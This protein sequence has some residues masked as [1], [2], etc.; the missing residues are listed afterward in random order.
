MKIPITQTSI[1]SSLIFLELLSNTIPPCHRFAIFTR[2]PA[3]LTYANPLPPKLYQ[4]TVELV[5]KTERIPSS[6]PQPLFEVSPYYGNYRT[7]GE[8]IP[9]PLF[10]P[11]AQSLSTPSSPLFPLPFPFPYILFHQAEWFCSSPSLPIT[12]VLSKA[13]SL[14]LKKTK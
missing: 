1:S 7:A 12:L 4:E 8:V 11:A 2:A 13:K 10:T 6:N 5:F 3:L 14:K 9:S